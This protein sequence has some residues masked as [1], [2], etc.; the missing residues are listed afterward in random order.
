MNGIGKGLQ[1]VLGVVAG[2]V[3]FVTLSATAVVQQHAVVTGG[4]ALGAIA[5]AA[6]V[7]GLCALG[8]Q[9]WRVSW[10][11]GVSAAMAACLLLGLIEGPLPPGLAPYQLLSLPATFSVGLGSLAVWVAFSVSVTLSVTTAR[12]GLPSQQANSRVREST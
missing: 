2:L 8:F 6:V 5:F 3:W 4:S 12:R 1:V 7:S 9:V 10:G 11:V